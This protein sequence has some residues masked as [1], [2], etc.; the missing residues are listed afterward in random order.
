MITAVI[1]EDS[2]LARLELQHQLG[3]HPQVALLGQA[4]D[5]DSAVSMINAV[6]PDLLFLDI[7]LPGGSGFDVLARIDTVPRVIFT[8]AFDQY[9]LQA[10][11]FNTIDYLLKPVEPEHLARALDKVRLE[12]RADSVRTSPDHPIFVK[13]GER[14]YLVKPREIRLFE[15]VGN[16]SRLHFGPNAPLVYRSLGAIE[17][18]LDPALF[19]RA[20]RQAIVNLGFVEQ[21]TPWVNGGLQ[22]TLRG[23][24]QIEVSRRQSQ[25][26]KEL[27]SL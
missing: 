17:E 9:A 10:F 25:R 20:S 15:A 3:A 8:T 16:Y 5:V 12:P 6:A 19:F 24:A 11:G 18:R 4:G 1:V 26:L 27:M 2:E 23:G 22:L 7:D 13:D 14:C 21:V